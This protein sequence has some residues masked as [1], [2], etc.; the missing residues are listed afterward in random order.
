MDSGSTLACA[1]RAFSLSPGSPK[2]LCS[3]VFLTENADQGCGVNY[4]HREMLS[5]RECDKMRVC[6]GVAQPGS[7]SALGADALVESSRRADGSNSLENKEMERFSLA[8]LFFRL[9]SCSQ[10]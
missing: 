4:T 5:S 7:A 3:G 9:L 1:T 8:H 6:R 2:Q 10:N